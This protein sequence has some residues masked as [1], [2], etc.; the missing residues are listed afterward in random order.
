[1][2]V[3]NLPFDVFPISYAYLNFQIEKWFTKSRKRGIVLVLWQLAPNFKSIKKMT[4]V[5]QKKKRS[6]T[7]TT[8]SFSQGEN[9]WQ[10]G[11]WIQA[12]GSEFVCEVFN[13]C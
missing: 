5:S 7:T 10:G 1:M 2:L 3:F 6:N 13:T 8:T 9:D 4:E 12:V 11:A